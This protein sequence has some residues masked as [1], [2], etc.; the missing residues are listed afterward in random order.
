VLVSGTTFNTSPHNSSSLTRSPSSQIQSLACL[1]YYLNPE[2]D[3]SADARDTAER[4]RPLADDQT[5]L[6][7]ALS[8][9]LHRHVYG[10]AMAPSY[11]NAVNSFLL[12]LVLGTLPHVH[13]FLVLHQGH[14][15]VNPHGFLHRPWSRTESV[16]GLVVWRYHHYLKDSSLS[17]SIPNPNAFPC[18]HSRC[19]SSITVILTGS[20]IKSRNI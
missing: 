6:S 11:M 1:L 13:C 5:L 8:S 19:A 18:L 20:G 10:S 7:S 3:K 2:D 14:L 9:P 15:T 16:G 12:A 17:R 4:H